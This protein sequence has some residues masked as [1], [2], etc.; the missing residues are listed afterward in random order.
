V[1]NAGSVTVLQRHQSGL[2]SYGPSEGGRP[3]QDDIAEATDDIDEV[4][5]DILKAIPD[6]FCQNAVRSGVALPRGPPLTL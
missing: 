2:P 6:K 3:P 4:M 5:D 1:L